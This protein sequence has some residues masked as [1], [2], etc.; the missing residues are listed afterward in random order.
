[1]RI[2]LFLLCFCYENTGAISW[3]CDNRFAF[4]FDMFRIFHVE[5]SYLDFT[6]FLSF[7]LIQLWFFSFFLIDGYYFLFFLLAFVFVFAFI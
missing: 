4:H 5:F 1:M 2:I 6:C 7:S 3:V